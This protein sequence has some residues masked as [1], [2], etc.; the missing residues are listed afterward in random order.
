MV[1]PAAGGRRRRAR[2]ALKAL[3]LLYR[4]RRCGGVKA[5]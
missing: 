3:K 4:R 5:W 1:D 2:H